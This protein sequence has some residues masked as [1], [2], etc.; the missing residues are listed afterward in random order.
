MAADA[1]QSAPEPEVPEAPDEAW[2][3]SLPTICEGEEDETP[4]E[5]KGYTCLYIYI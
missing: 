1:L 5:K 2:A 3:V 4:A